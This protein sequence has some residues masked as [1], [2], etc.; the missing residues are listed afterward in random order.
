[1]RLRK[2]TQNDPV[3]RLAVSVKQSTVKMI[4]DYR[5][6]YKAT[7]GEEIEKSHLVEEIIRD[8]I[9]SDRD[10]AKAAGVSKK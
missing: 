1:M 3:E 4:E 2:V 10:Y 9:L 6:H 5:A 7:Y 8:F